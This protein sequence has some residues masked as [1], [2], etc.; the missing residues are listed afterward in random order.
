MPDKVEVRD[1]SFLTLLALQEA[2]CF[3]RHDETKAQYLAA[4]HARLDD[5][6][7]F[8]GGG[9]QAQDPSTVL[10]YMRALRA[11]TGVDYK[12]LNELASGLRK[13]LNAINE[14]V[15]KNAA[16]VAD[17][18]ASADLLSAMAFLRSLH[19]QLLAHKQREAAKRAAASVLRKRD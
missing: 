8:T 2:D 5:I 17:E 15:T 3:R 13:Q 18:I 6:F 19:Q 12:G 1:L 4:F 9:L 14:M 11:A 16:G 7:D 10:I